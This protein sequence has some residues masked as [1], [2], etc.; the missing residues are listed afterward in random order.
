MRL[1]SARIGKSSGCKR[2]KTAFCLLVFS[3]VSGLSCFV[4]AQ[5][6]NSPI[7]VC[8]KDENGGNVADKLF[9][10]IFNTAAK[11]D[12]NKPEKDKCFTSTAGRFD[13]TKTYFVVAAREDKLGVSAFTLNGE[14]K[15]Q[16]PVNVT[17]KK[18]SEKADVKSITI[19]AEDKNKNP[20]QIES[21]SS[22]VQD[23][24]F[25]PDVDKDKGCAHWQL[26]AA[27][28][29][30][31]QLV[32]A[33]AS[34]TPAFFDGIK[35]IPGLLLL[36]V[37]VSLLLSLGIFLTIWRMK[38]LQEVVM[39]GRLIGEIHENVR[40]MSGSVHHI[41]NKVDEWKT[42]DSLSH[43]TENKGDGDEPEKLATADIDAATAASPAS[44]NSADRVVQ[45]QPVLPEAAEISPKRHVAGAK[46]KYSEFCDGK[47]VDHFSLM[48]LGD[49]SASQLVAEAKVKLREQNFGTYIAFRASEESGEAWVFPQPGLHF[50]PERFGAVFPNLTE[51]EYQN[52]SVEP[53]RAVNTQPK[54]WSIE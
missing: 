24:D 7:K 29:Y 17:L 47:Q 39:G 19:C 28:E 6:I 51:Q 40:L 30:S 22:S 43:E 1:F 16:P 8:V 54:L 12:N 11:I 38:N 45:E 50:T 4:Q 34:Q 26:G 52:G 31:L 9:I 5:I 41:K 37:M 27:V 33:S 49:S 46:Q 23:A 14:D 18:Q 2:L 32:T 21:I 48:P 53:K 25:K 10:T 20:V 35:G 13:P 44:V 15:N 36:L 42:D 3:I